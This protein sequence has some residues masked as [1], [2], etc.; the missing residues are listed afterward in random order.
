MPIAFYQYRTKL[1]CLYHLQMGRSMSIIFLTSS[2][3]RFWELWEYTDGQSIHAVCALLMC[4]AF[5]VCGS[6]PYF[7]SIFRHN[8]LLR[9]G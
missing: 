2:M 7:T 3:N 6:W 9:E 5:S 1:F 4:A 8:Q